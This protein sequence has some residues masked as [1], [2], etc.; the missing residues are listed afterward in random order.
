MAELLQK[1]F[2]DCADTVPIG[3]GEPAHCFNFGFRTYALQSKALLYDEGRTPNVQHTAL[4]E[5]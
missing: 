1:T 2:T 4:H 3:G 5:V